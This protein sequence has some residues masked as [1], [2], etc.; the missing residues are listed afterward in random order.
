MNCNG[1]RDLFLDVFGDSEHFLTSN[2]QTDEQNTLKP[3][4]V[5]D[6]VGKMLGSEVQISSLCFLCLLAFEILT[7]LYS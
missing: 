7:C 1:H 2:F 5:P 4:P 6:T 3:Q